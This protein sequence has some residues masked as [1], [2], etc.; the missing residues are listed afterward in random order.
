VDGLVHFDGAVGLARRQEHVLGP[1]EVLA[2]LEQPRPNGP[3][4]GP[5]GRRL[6]KEVE[7]RSRKV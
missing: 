5:F 7:P 6:G 2:Q 1:A 4:V 3:V